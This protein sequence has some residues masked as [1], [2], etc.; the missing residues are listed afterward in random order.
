MDKDVVAG[1][2]KDS[3]NRDRFKEEPAS[4]WVD[5]LKKVGGFE[6]NKS[7]KKQSNRMAKRSDLGFHMKKDQH[8][9]NRCSLD[10]T[11]CHM[12]R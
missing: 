5:L 3:R 12:L 11:R 4:T 10:R 7:F 1:K 2:V 8:C 9:M 6:V